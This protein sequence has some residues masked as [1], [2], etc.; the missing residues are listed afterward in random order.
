VPVDLGRAPRQEDDVKKK[1]KPRVREPVSRETFDRLC[2]TC[3]A[4]EDEERR[5]STRREDAMGRRIAN[6]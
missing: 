3:R 1:S 4:R 2:E 6:L 5:E